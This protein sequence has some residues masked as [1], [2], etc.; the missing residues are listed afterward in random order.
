MELVL[1]AALAALVFAVCAWS[2]R[3]L[4]SHYQDG[5]EVAAVV[6][7]GACVL[8]TLAV[9]RQSAFDADPRAYAGL[10]GAGGGGLF[11]GYLR[12]SERDRRDRR[13]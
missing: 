10:L 12:E 5:W 4:A 7:I 2:G 11:L 6:A 3:L 1:A 9:T 8:G 13:D